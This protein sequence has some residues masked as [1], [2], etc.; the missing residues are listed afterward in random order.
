M[1]KVFLNIVFRYY[2]Q[3]AYDVMTELYIKDKH[4]ARQLLV[5]KVQRYGSTTLFELSQ[6][7][8]LMKFVE[9]TA[10]QTKLNIIWKGNILPYTSHAKVFSK[11]LYG[12]FKLR[13]DL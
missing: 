5:Q 2:E 10:C 11:L 9:H 1:L 7:N 4:K 8:H 6:H 3:L 12:N 13:H